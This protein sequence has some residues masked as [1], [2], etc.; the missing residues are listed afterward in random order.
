[1]NQ[2]VKKSILKLL[3]MLPKERK[4]E[5]IFNVTKKSD[6]QV[7]DYLEE[8]GFLQIHYEVINT[9]CF[10]IQETG[11]NVHLW[12]RMSDASWK[13]NLYQINRMLEANWVEK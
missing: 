1:M 2:E 11:G 9:Y 3:S 7:Y 12:E 6:S 8:Q 13:I 5:D 4:N 10:R